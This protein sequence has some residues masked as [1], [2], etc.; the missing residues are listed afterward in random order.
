MADDGYLWLYRL[1][2]NLD[3]VTSGLSQ[4]GASQS[5]WLT[6]D[7]FVNKLSTVDQP[8]RPTQASIPPGL[9]NE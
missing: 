2:T 8:T 9:V 5:I 6:G 7:Q 1:E 3:S 4:T